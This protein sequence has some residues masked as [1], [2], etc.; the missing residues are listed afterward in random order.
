MDIALQI[1]Q[2][3]AEKKVWDKR[4][5]SQR[6]LNKSDLC[7]I[8]KKWLIPA[9]CTEVQP[10][11]VEE[12][13]KVYF[14]NGEWITEKTEEQE[15]KEIQKSVVDVLQDQI[16]ELKKQ[17]EELKC[18]KEEVKNSIVDVRREALELSTNLILQKEELNTKQKEGDFIE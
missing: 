18:E 3:K 11:E 4:D 13:Y 6:I 12:G 7:P 1:I 14:K 10:P 8:S 2:N 17:L 5:G 15:V 16:S 9:N